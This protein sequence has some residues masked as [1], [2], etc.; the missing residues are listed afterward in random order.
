MLSLSSN[1][2]HRGKSWQNSNITTWDFTRKHNAMF[3]HCYASW[4]VNEVTQTNRFMWIEKSNELFVLETQMIDTL[5]S[6][7]LIFHIKQ[8]T[9]IL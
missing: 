1:N 9:L 7:M 6:R 3:D 2:S 5:E 4:M 8:C